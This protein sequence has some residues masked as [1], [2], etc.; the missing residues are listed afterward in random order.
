MQQ[1][2]IYGMPCHEAK[3]QSELP[4]FLDDMFTELTLEQLPDPYSDTVK[5][6]FRQIELLTRQLAGNDDL[7]RRYRIYDRSLPDYISGFTFKNDDET[8]TKH[9][10][11]VKD[12]I[13]DV[14]PLVYKIKLWYRRPR[15]FQL[16]VLHNIKIYPMASLTA[17]C[18]AWPSMHST[19]GYVIG[20]VCGNKFPDAWK[21]YKDL[22]EDIRHSRM[23]MGLCLPSDVDAGQ[24]LASII[25]E[26][27][28]FKVK[29]G[30]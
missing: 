29:Y 5:K 27:K 15:P 28:E 8:T 26:N 3:K 10:N 4:S 22:A 19:L 30:L 12:I 13:T 7:L 17:H 16:A 25:L 14:W 11:I 9:S 6:E 20:N 23:C 18:P 24:R 2:L 1:E 21:Y